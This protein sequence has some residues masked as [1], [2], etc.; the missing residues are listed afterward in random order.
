MAIKKLLKEGVTYNSLRTIFE[1]CCSFLDFYETMKSY[2]IERKVAKVMALHFSGKGFLNQGA[3]TYSKLHEAKTTADESTEDQSSGDHSV[4]QKNSECVQQVKLATEE[5]RPESKSCDQDAGGGED[6]ER[7]AATAKRQNFTLKCTTSTPLSLMN[8]DFSSTSPGRTARKPSPKER[9]QKPSAN[10]GC[11]VTHS[12]SEASECRKS[13][14][15]GKRPQSNVAEAEVRARPS[16]PKSRT[17]SGEKRRE[18]FN[19]PV[20]SN[21]RDPRAKRE[22]VDLSQESTKEL[23]K[24]KKT[25]S[26][27]RPKETPGEKKTKPVVSDISSNDYEAVAEIKQKS[28]GPSCDPSPSSDQ[29]STVKLDEES[30][31]TV[32]SS[33]DNDSSEKRDGQNFTRIFVGDIAILVPVDDS[34]VCDSLTNELRDT[35][36]DRQGEL[37]ETSV[38]DNVRSGDASSVCS[39]SLTVAVKPVQMETTILYESSSTS[40]PSPHRTLSARHE[41]AAH[42]DSIPQHTEVVDKEQDHSSKCE[43]LETLVLA[44]GIDGSHS[45]MESEFKTVASS[46]RNCSKGSSE[47]AGVC[48]DDKSDITDKTTANSNEAVFAI[49]ETNNQNETN[50]SSLSVATVQVQGL[51]VEI[52]A[53][54]PESVT[55]ENGCKSGPYKELEQTPL[56]SLSEDSL[57]QVSSGRF[58]MSEGFACQDM[59]TDEVDENRRDL[60][61]ELSSDTSSTSDESSVDTFSRQPPLGAE[62]G[63]TPDTVQQYPHQTAWVES[64]NEGVH[65]MPYAAGVNYPQGSFPPYAN[66]YGTFYQ[67]Q[68]ALPLFKPYFPSFGYPNQIRPMVSPHVLQPQSQIFLPPYHQYRSQVM[69]PGAVQK[70]TG[71]PSAAVQPSQF[72]PQV[73]QVLQGPTGYAYPP[74]PFYG[75]PSQQAQESAGVLFD[76]ESTQPQHILTHSSPTP[77]FASPAMSEQKDE[78]GSELSSSTS[79]GSPFEIITL[80]ASDSFRPLCDYSTQREESFSGQLEPEFENSLLVANEGSNV[81]QVVNSGVSEMANDNDK[82]LDN[83]KDSGYLKQSKEYSSQPLPQDKMDSVH[84]QITILSR[85]ESIVAME[86]RLSPDGSCVDTGGVDFVSDTIFVHKMGNGLEEK[87]ACQ[88]TLQDQSQNNG[89]CRPSSE[90]AKPK[91]PSPKP[92]RI[93]ENLSRKNKPAMS[94]PVSCQKAGGGSSDIMSVSDPASVRQSLPPKTLDQ[95]R[96]ESAV[97]YCKKTKTTRSPKTVRF[98]NESTEHESTNGISRAT[99]DDNTQSS[100]RGQR[101]ESFRMDERDA[102]RLLE[103]R[104]QRHTKER[105]LG[106]EST[107]VYAK[108]NSRK[109]INNRMRRP[110]GERNRPPKHPPSAVKAETDAKI[111]PNNNRG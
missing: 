74:V 34:E 75:N 41:D 102:S 10:T 13:D 8:E 19:K 49:E 61:A 101:T 9:R 106:T 28:R 3:K 20:K 59:N 56:A 51:Q 31:P 42:L 1:E 93:K 65:A 50:D 70:V 99:T 15:I 33:L 40:P 60:Q 89:D 44:S 21:K 95:H 46:E 23:M 14:S 54:H 108:R 68:Q 71:F 84:K 97:T 53:N 25:K 105:T 110:Y 92:Q 48:G 66:P 7:E 16:A 85:D 52:E 35:N 77:E 43:E 79:S 87:T 80:P 104:S 58:V 100:C 12:P 27:D 38:A 72:R 78:S 18:A 63:F 11:K 6:W 39:E 86:K 76:A 62:R 91:C 64:M 81:A 26:K 98:S 2:G 94:Q 90:S 82:Y 88:R 103:G 111:D 30:H 22:T 83:T 17:E 4:Q 36:S 55:G 67:T 29:G 24:G 109:R 32:V 45:Q 47:E 69:M 73:Y 107:P 96:S 37:E 57:D 5:S